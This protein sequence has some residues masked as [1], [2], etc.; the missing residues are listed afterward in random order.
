MAEALNVYVSRHCFGTAEATRLAGEVS[1]KL[2]RLQ[3]KVIMLDEMPM[4]NTMSVPPT[5]S[6]F[7][8]DRLLFLGNP[9]IEELLSKISS[10][11]QGKGKQP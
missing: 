8:D 3:V 9:R 5:P 6:Y 10:A 7:L 4:I 1:Q 11:R 2:P